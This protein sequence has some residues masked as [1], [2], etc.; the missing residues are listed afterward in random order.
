MLAVLLLTTSLAWAGEVRVTLFDSPC[1]LKGPVDSAQL[2]RIHEISPEQ[3]LVVNSEP[4]PAWVKQVKTSFER[5]QK[6]RG[7]PSGLDRYREKARRRLEAQ[8][9]F[10]REF[11]HWNP[12]GPAAAEAPELKKFLGAITAQLPQQESVIQE[13]SAYMKAGQWGAALEVYELAIE[14]DPEEYFHSAIAKL[15]IQYNCATEPEVRP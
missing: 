11:S 5:I 9:V 15:K 1:L 6:A 10:A 8:W 12:Q 3:I 7:L 14:P 2:K 4:T 13:I